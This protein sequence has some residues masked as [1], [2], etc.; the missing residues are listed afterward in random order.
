MISCSAKV[1]QKE[2]IKRYEGLH[3]GVQYFQ[4]DCYRKTT[5]LINVRLLCSMASLV[6]VASTAMMMAYESHYPKDRAVGY[7]TV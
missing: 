7:N 6:P 5:S 1:G 3:S 4:K 2:A